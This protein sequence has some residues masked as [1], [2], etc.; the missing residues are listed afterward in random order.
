VKNIVISPSLLSADF[1]KFGSEV[2]EAETAGADWLHIDVMDGHF[3]PNLTFGLPFIEAIKRRS[4]LPLDVHIMVANPDH[5]AED[6]VKAGA[7]FLSFHLEAAIHPYRII[8]NIKSKGAK[9]GLALNPG[10]PVS[11]V[12]PMLADIDFVLLLSVNPGFSG[13]KFMPNVFEKLKQLTAMCKKSQRQDLLVSVDGGVSAVNIGE[14][15]RNGANCFVTGS[16]FFSAPNKADAIAK[17]RAAAN[18]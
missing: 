17:L 8:Q 10:T 7:D 3:V 9:A 18:T 12:E 5:V 14:L 16:Y 15:V 11:L 13:Q 6:Y 1:L 2:E 4:R